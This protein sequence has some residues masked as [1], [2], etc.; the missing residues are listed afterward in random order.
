M[1]GATSLKKARRQQGES[2]EVGLE[3]TFPSL[4][5]RLF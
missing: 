2:L 3:V 4:L 5:K 1:S